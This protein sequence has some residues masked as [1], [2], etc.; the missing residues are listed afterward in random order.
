MILTKDQIKRVS[1]ILDNAGQVTLGSL[2]IPYLSASDND[3][4]IYSSVL[5]TIL[6]WIIAISVEKG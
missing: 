4:L 1:N 3:T 6:L 5:V 2:V